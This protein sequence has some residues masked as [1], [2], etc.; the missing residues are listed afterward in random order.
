MLHI[1][2]EQPRDVEPS[3]ILKIGAQDVKM[4]VWLLQQLMVSEPTVP[5][6][7]CLGRRKTKKKG[8]KSEERWRES[9]QHRQKQK[10]KA[11]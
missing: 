11:V 3:D 7:R 5:L 9:N 6:M 1:R 10:T 2:K 4:R 8:K